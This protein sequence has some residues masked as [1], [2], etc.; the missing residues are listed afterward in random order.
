MT[1]N[2]EYKDT[3]FTKLFSEPKRLREL[4]NALAG[5]CY[6]DDTPIEITTLD[7]IFVHG[8][9]NDVSFIIDNRFVV[10]VEHQSTVN[11]NMPLRFLLYMARVYEKLIDNKAAYQEKLIKIPT[12]EFIVLYNGVKPLPNVQAMKLSDAFLAVGDAYELFGCLELTVKV[13]NIN[14]DGDRALLKK[15]EALNG[16]ASFVGRVR[17]NLGG[18]MDLH[19]AIREAINYYSSD[20]V[21]SKFLNQHGSEVVNMLLNAEFDINIAKEVWQEEAR[22]EGRMEGRQEGRQEG[23]VD[24]HY[25]VAR[26][27]LKRKRPIDE[28]IED[29]SLSREEIES[30]S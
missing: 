13:V 5:T 22:Q 28:I 6:G 14:P 17:Q 1:T 2:R 11:E 16:Y 24:G 25:E 15:S 21:L 4:Y 3:F 9:R 23:R 8:L 19:S 20:G 30:L 10:L 18:G 27:L 26:K 12:P 7:E 29:T